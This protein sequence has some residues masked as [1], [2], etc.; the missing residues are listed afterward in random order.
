[1]SLAVA[2]MFFTTSATWDVPLM[3]SSNPNYLPKVLSPNTITYKVRAST[4]K[5]W[6]NTD[7]WFI[8]P[9]KQASTHAVGGFHV[10]LMH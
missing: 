2:G 4:Y 6:G 9:N 8:T 5:F 10:L 7:I 3:S 1:M